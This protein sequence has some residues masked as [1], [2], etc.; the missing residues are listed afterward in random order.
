MDE[1]ELHRELDKLTTLE[2]VRVF[3]ER[4]ADDIPVPD[5]RGGTLSAMSLLGQRATSLYANFHYSRGSPTEFAPVLAVRP[6]VEMVILTKWISLEP[7]LHTFLYLADSDASELAHMDAIKA[8]ARVRGQPIPETPDDPSEEKQ[9]NRDRAI[10]KLKEL[11]RNY[12][13]GRIMPNVRRMAAEVSSKIP[14]HKTVMDDAYV[15]AY[16]TFSPWEHTEASSFKTTA[17][18][19]APDQ[20]RWIGD[21][22]PWHPGDVEAIASSMY[23]YILETVFLAI[24]HPAAATARLVREYIIKNHVRSD[25]V[26]PPGDKPEASSED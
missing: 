4:I 1:D 26:R 17:E 7:E 3:L 16:K 20:W 22:S 6:L 9:A 23:A 12:G 5:H 11:G 14:G 19:T 10:A 18:E 13:D 25:R 24:G 2:L 8:H 21:K 15:Y